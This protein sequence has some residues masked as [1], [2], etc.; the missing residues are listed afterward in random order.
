MSAITRTGNF[1]VVVAPRSLGDFGYGSISDYVIC[2]DPVRRQREYAQ[3]CDE[4]AQQIRRHVDGVGGVA[5]EYDTLRECEHC[6]DRW[7][8]DSADYNGGCCQAD[9][10]AE[11]ARAEG[12]GK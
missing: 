6:G 9:Q 8:E 12:G 4:I 2:P 5:V 7:T 11:D 10:W 1:R 3:A